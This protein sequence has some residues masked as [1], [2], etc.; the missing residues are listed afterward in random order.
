MV[1]LSHSPAEFASQVS[2]ALGEDSPE[3]R[4]RRREIAAEASW[5][6]RADDLLG[7]LSGSE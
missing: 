3:W 6:R 7:S 1:Y 2:A 4:R 5:D